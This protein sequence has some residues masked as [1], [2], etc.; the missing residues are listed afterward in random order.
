MSH[1]KPFDKAGRGYW[2]EIWASDT[3]PDPINPRDKSLAN[4]VNRGFHE[5]FAS[6]VNSESRPKILLEIGCGSSAWLPYFRREFGLEIW[7]LD[8][9]ARGCEMAMKVLERSGEHG[10]IVNA[11]FFQPP[12]ELAGKFDLVVSFGVF[13]HFDDT[14]SAITAMSAFLS[15]G[16]VSVTVIPNMVGL[17]GKLQKLLNPEVYQIHVPLSADRLS[18]AHDRSVWQLLTCD[19]FLSTNFWVCNLHGTNARNLS[20]VLRKG[21][22]ALFTRMSLLVWAIERAGVVFRSSRVLSPYIVSVA[23]KK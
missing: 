13:E 4:T 2:D 18:A 23:R 14:Q 10:Q 20:G 8:Y 1:A 11:D 19:Y 9:S 16:G 3:I 5:L 12:E 22:L 21:V 7:G 6:L 15:S 17:V